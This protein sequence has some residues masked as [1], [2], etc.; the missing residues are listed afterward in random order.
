MT[1]VN[2]PG[3]L[4]VGGGKAPVVASG[5]TITI[6]RHRVAGLFQPLPRSQ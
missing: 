2:G 3:R 4:T 6:G 5:R 1:L